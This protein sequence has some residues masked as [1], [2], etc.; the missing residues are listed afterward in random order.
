MTLSE[1]KRR[2]RVGTV[3]QAVGHYNPNVSGPRQ[4]TK[5]QTN[6]FWFSCAAF[7]KAWCGWPKASQTKSIDADTI[8]LLRDSG[9]PMSTLTI[10]REEV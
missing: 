7:S 10:P 6:G 5:I 8:L 3:I 4:V 9:E 1:A 2:I